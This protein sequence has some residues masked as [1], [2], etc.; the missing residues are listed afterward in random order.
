MTDIVNNA[1]IRVVADASGVEAGLR[2]AVNAANRAGQAITQTGERSATAARAVENSQRNIIASI[3]R[4]TMAMEAGG[5]S[6]AAYYESMARNRGVDPASLTPYLNQLRAVEAAQTQATQATQAQAAAAREL[7]QAQA[8]KESFLAGLREQIALFGKSA[9]EV[10]RYRAAQAGA[11]QESSMLIL[12]LQN[13]RAAQQQSEAA[14]RAQAAAQREAAQAET[15]KTTFLD[16]LR[17]QIALFGKSTEGILEYRA[18]QAGAAAEAA[19]LIA[20]LRSLREAHEQAGAAARQAAQAQRDSAQAQTA[21]DN[22]LAGLR[23]QIALFGKSTEEVMRYRAAQAGAASAADPLIAQLRALQQ[24]QD[25]VAASARAAA[26]AQQ[27]AAQTQSRR[28]SFLE[29]LREQIALYGRSTEEVQRHHAAQLGLTAVAEPLIAQLHAMR[30][31]QE[32]VAAAARAADQAQREAL[33]AQAGKDSFIAGLREQIAMFGL[34]TEEVNRYRAAQLGLTSTTEP[35]I[36]KLRDLRLA[37]EQQTYATQMEAQAQRELS[38]VQASRTSFLKG[39][40]QQVAAIGKTRTE[41]L[42]L[43]AAQLGITTQAK[44]LLDQLHAQDQAFRNGGMSAA[45]MSAAMRGV[46]AQ[47]TDIIVSL[48]GGQ[49]PLTVLMQQGGQ[50]RDMFGGVGAAAR[51][52]GGA[53]LG[54]INPYTVTVAVLGTLAYAYKAGHEEAVQYSRAL[55]MT[56]NFAGTT[57]GQMADMAASMKEINGSQGV[58]AKALTTLAST[59]AIAGANLEKFGTVAVDAQRVLGKSVEDTAKEF[60]ALGKDPLTALRAMGDQYGFVTTETYLA[61]RAAQVQGR[62]I[63]AARIAQNAY[64]DGIASQKEKVLAVLSVWERAWIGIKSAT[65]SAWDAVVEFSGSRE[66]GP[67][68]QLAALD[69]QRKALEESVERLKRIGKAREGERYDPSRDRD[70]LGAQAQIAA[71]ERAVKSINEKAAADKKAGE[72]AA[73]KVQREAAEREWEEKQRI[74]FTRAEQR[75][76]ALRAAQTRGEQLGIPQSSTDPNAITIDKQLLAIRREYNDVFVLGIDTSIT[77][78][79]KRGELEETL[80]QRALAQIQAKRDAGEIT[81]D[82]ALR[83]T[84]AVQLAIMDNQKRGLQEQLALVGQKIGS[85]REQED[86]AGQIAKLGE[87]RLSRQ[88]QL[89]NDLAA[90]QRNRSQASQDLYMQGVKAASAELVGLQDQ[91]KAQQLANE[92]IGLSKEAVA[93]LQ[94]ERMLGIATLKEEAAAQ[95]EAVEAG[96]ITAALYREQAEELRKLAL[97]KQQGAVNEGIAEANKKAQDSL[98][99]FLDPARAQTF[100]EALREAFGTAGDSITKMTGALDAFGQRQA[101]IAKQRGNADLLLRNKEINEV[102]HLEIVDKLNEEGAKNRLAGYGAMTSAAA[103]FFGEQSKGYKALQAASQV[104]H[105]AELA[106]TLAELVPKGISAVL[107]Q[108]SGDPYTAFGRMA[109]MAAIVAALGVAIGGVG[110][111]GVNLSESRQKAQGTGS[112]LGSDEKSESIA[113]SLDIMESLASKELGISTG[114]LRSLRNIEA[115]I[116][117]FSSL[118]VRTTGVSGDFGAGSA[119]RGSADAFGRSTLGVLATG[120]FIGLALDKLTG[121]WVGKITG[122]VLNSVFG[123]KKTVEDTGFTMSKATYASILTDGVSASQ[124]ADI[125]KDGGWFKKDKY[126][127]QLEGL[128]AEGNRQIGLVLTSI[129]DTVFEAGKLLQINAGDFSARLNSF[130]VDIGKVTLKG[131]TGEEIQKE[132]SAVFSKIGDDLASFGVAG[133]T[134][135]QQVGEGALETLARLAS[136]YAGLDAVLAS[137]GK[138][139]GATGMAS[140]AAREELLSM[141]GGIEELADQASSF[142]ENYLTEAER[143]APVQKYVA[144]QL[145]A[146]G[147]ATLRS[148]EAFKQYVLGLDLTSS[149]QR[150]QYAQL[151]ALQ[152]AFAQVYPAIEDT[153]VTLASA[154]SALTDAYKAETAAIDATIS[155]MSSFAATLKSLRDNT[156]LGGLSPLSPM[157]KYAEAKAQYDAVL[158]AAR[159]GDEAA[160]SQYQGAFNAFLTASRAVFASSSQYRSDFDYAQASTAEA[161]R[162][163]SAQVDVGKA[164]LEALKLSVKGLIDVEKSVLSVREAILQLHTVMNKNTSPLTAVAPPVNAPIPYSSYGTADKEALVAEVKALRTELS[165]LRADANRQTGDQMAAGARVSSESAQ[166]I[167]TTVKSA[168]LASTANERVMPE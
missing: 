19:P 131:K 56:G 89:E 22:F 42:E 40:E 90:A 62:T 86:L 101:Q 29:G 73:L 47:M 58:S 25:Q 65:S 155:R 128:G 85:Q 18:A 11:A 109:A 118:L 119:T 93:A 92:E 106:M 150:E 94:A 5:R 144:E 134:D 95:L 15:S 168:I 143:L 35:L 72:D 160:Q 12:Q 123:G 74:L 113:K 27:D 138:S 153:S 161:E 154:K 117:S 121:G 43:Q 20:Q 103:G 147:L 3:Q 13:M 142:A 122:S 97:L 165:G 24:A 64:A 164:Q 141:V 54:L 107:S 70:V 133:L 50:L 77:A 69:K 108:G 163:A 9:D 7:A 2:P 30:T 67:E 137:I 81:E 55:I 75:D 48:Q 149:A 159:G 111:G 68:Q 124:Y 82:D 152:E 110:S 148:R 91:V 46:P 39:L 6:T 87:Q 44:P 158:A 83:Q 49:A 157:Q 167:A 80:S 23:E 14:A 41:M 53:V 104:F 52:L 34:S 99:E 4:T 26:Q 114:M 32:Q 84:A 140:I 8:S 132:L 129:Y 156:L 61:V 146:M 16:G 166:F 125:K 135:F 1:T 126:S 31:A 71:N 79:R 28:D 33:Q 63:D 59:G 105:A 66:L 78:L 57:A 130:V 116:N 36:A 127:T 17:E 112:V 100:G 98:K 10:Q 37:Q 139:F 45:A 115:G 145:G 96:S 162:W 60:A 76:R 88:Q 136:N 102:K 51:A 151:M 120:G 38:Q 21:R